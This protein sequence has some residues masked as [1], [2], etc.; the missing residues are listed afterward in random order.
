MSQRLFTWAADGVVETAVA[1]LDT[2][3]IAETVGA[4]D[5]VES[6]S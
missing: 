2:V 6:R 1:D 3:R 4:G 5:V